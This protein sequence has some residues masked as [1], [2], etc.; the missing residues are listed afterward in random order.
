MELNIYSIYD[1]KAQAFMQPF[2]SPNDQMAVRSF[3]AACKE[4]DLW[5]DNAADFS[6]F[7]LGL[8]D[9]GSGSIN[10]QYDEIV[11]ASVFTE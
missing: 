6:L 3:Q 11:N 5:S 10:P 8:F 4:N 7:Y 1:K 9:D 2:F